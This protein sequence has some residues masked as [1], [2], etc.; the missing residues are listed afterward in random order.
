MVLLCAVAASLSFEAYKSY[1]KDQRRQR[2]KETRQC[3]EY[4]NQ[5]E[6]YARR[7]E[8][9]AGFIGGTLHSNL[10]QND[11]EGPP[12]RATTTS[13]F[14]VPDEATYATVLREMEQAKAAFEGVSAETPDVVWAPVVEHEDRPAF[15]AYMSRVRPPRPPP[16][17]RGNNSSTY[18]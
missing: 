6:R 13:K 1:K 5:F 12:G 17:G 10:V 16:S 15:E 18:Y 3:D 4:F 8:A 11:S 14:V 9:R 2:K 7:A